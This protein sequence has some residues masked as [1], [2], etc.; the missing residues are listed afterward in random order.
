MKKIRCLII[1]DEPI[2]QEIIETFI[3]RLPFL[4]WVAKTNNVFETYG[5]LSRNTIDLIFATLKCRKSPG[6]NAS[7]LYR[8]ARLIL[9]CQ[10]H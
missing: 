8:N 9:H 3:G 1:E 5:E 10:P 7:N 2:A 4:E 6:S